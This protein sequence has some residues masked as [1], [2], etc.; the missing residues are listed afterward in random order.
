M[1]ILWSIVV[2]LC[3]IGAA[4]W[5]VLNRQFLIDQVTVWQYQPTDQIAQL[6][7]DA[8]MSD[9][10]RFLFYASE[11]RLDGTQAF[12]EACKRQEEG[13]AILGCYTNGRVF[14]YD[15][16][17]E[18][19]D[20]VKEVTAA[21][22]MLHAA[23]DRLSSG[24]RQALAVELEAAYK[25]VTNDAL[26]KRMEYY[27]RTEPGQRANELHSILATEFDTLP[28]ALEEYY[29]NY[30]TDRKAVVALHGQYSDKFASLADNT[31]TLRTQLETLSSEIAAESKQYEEAITVLNGRIENFNARA[32][33]GSFASREQFSAER[34]M[35]MQEA[36]ALTQRRASINTKVDE[37]ERLRLQYNGLVDE[38][39][40]MQQALDSSLAPAP[41]L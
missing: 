27:A 15:V 30:F 33:A 16:K 18:R 6:A 41:S 7:T 12:N 4:A 11:P 20:G 28:D 8:K 26:A 36:D 9:R 3:L 29:Q 21:H 38:S 37:Y 5:V 35:L 14:V 17:D 2:S 23:Y 10:G 40:S 39:N 34:S 13:N 25:S 24:E 31:A 19:L 1:K 22:E 32:G